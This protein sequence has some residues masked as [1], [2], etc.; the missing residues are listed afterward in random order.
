MFRLC[1]DAGGTF[2]ESMVFANEI[3]LREFE[4]PTTPR[5]FTETEEL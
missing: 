3:N 4:T 2:T 5:D 1:I